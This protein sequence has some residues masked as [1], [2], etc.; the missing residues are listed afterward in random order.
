MEVYMQK[1][2]AKNSGLKMLLAKY[3]QIF[4]IPENLNHYSEEDYQIA[5]KKFIKFALYEGN[6]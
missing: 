4:R 1:E 6:I 5:E 3:Q 2:T